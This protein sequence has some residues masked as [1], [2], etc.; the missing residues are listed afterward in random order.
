[1]TRQAGVSLALGVTVLALL[2]TLQVQRHALR[3]AALRSDSLEVAA[4]SSR[5]WWDGRFQV[6]ARRAYQVEIQLAT[7]LKQGQATAAS[8]VHARL[9]ADSLQ[10]VI[11]GQVTHDSAVGSATARGELAAESL[12]V[13]VRADVLIQ[14]VRALGPLT[15]TFTWNVTRHPVLLDVALVCL[16]GH[17]AEARIS[18]PSHVPLTITGAASRPDVCYPPPRWQPFSLRPPSLP[19]LVGAGLVGYLLR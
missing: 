5:R 17:R 1:M 11:E 9:E 7:A 14:P 16:P 10:R 8:L 12:G 3:A 2:A 18:T 15:S 4:D 19:W 13:T 6:A